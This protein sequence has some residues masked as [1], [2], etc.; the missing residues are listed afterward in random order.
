MYIKELTLTNIG[1]YRHKNTFDLRINNKQNVILIGGKNGAGKT[2]FLEA[3][4]LGL[5]GAYGYGYRTEN[6]SYFQQVT[7]LLNN[8]A[9]R[10]NEGPFE[11]SIIFEQ[12]EDYQTH[13]YELTRAW[14]KEKSWA[15]TLTILKNNRPLTP[16]QMNT[17]IANWRSLMPPQLLD[18]TMFDGEKISSIL[19]D[20]R[21]S[22]YLHDLLTVV[23]N[24]NLFSS[25][26][27]N[28]TNYAQQQINNQ[29]MTDLEQTIIEMNEKKL[30]KNEKLEEINA[31]LNTV[32]EEL[33]KVEDIYQEAK[34]HFSKHGGLQ[35]EERENL[36]QS[37]TKIEEARKNRIDEVQN[38]VTTTL[39]L[40]LVRDLIKETREQ[41]EREE[42]IELAQQ[43]DKRLS[44]KQLTQILE[45][46]QVPLQQDLVQT[47][48]EEL[49]KT[50]TPV[51]DTTTIHSASLVEKLKVEQAYETVEQPLAQ[52][53]M[54]KLNKNTEDLKDLR[55]LRNRLKTNDTTSEFNDLI[56]TM[57][58]TQQKVTELEQVLQELAVEK[59]QVELELQNV[60]DDLHKVRLELR[61]MKKTS[62]SL[63][64]AEKIIA[65]SQKYREIQRVQTVQDIER[66]TRE[67]LNKLMQKGDYIS[68]ITIDPNSF[69]VTLFDR[70]G[71]LL[72]KQ[73]ISA[74]EQQL[75]LMSLIWAIFDRADRKLPF[76]FDTL[77]G[78]LDQT[79]KQTILGS[80]IPEF[81]QQTIIL[82][83]DSEIDDRHYKTIKPYVAKE[84]TLT[85]ENDTQS[86]KIGHTY[87]DFLQG[88][89]L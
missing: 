15:E 32:S 27:E 4:K 42:S 57:E 31:N 16:E 12:T 20:D 43:V 71:H 82:S 18:F 70:K 41:M 9:Q 8:E 66:L 73:M 89:N 19:K 78:R 37:I 69:D 46:H 38:F 13:T 51:K 5:F 60:L 53:Y 26:E 21:L 54:N 23:F 22:L 30:A 65:L 3:M 44:T 39:P 86:S 10:K 49:L 24:W 7:S 56:A 77:L 85:F 58:Q 1:S 2:T 72:D 17:W 67:R 80:F 59:E 48:K 34:S 83:T 87:Y 79:H 64:E 35:K 36:L 29:K 52:L 47:L 25:L 84:Y 61:T 45:S 28:L 33:T 11:I 68:A 81:A 6:A 14:K 62:S 88:G 50:L 63:L 40:L 55:A 74:G 76:V 75:L